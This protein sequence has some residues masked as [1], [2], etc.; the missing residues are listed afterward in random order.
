MLIRIPKPWEKI[1]A[2]ETPE[3]YFENRRSFLKLGGAAASALLLGTRSAV[4]REAPSSASPGQ[5]APPAPRD[6][7]FTLDPPVTPERFSSRHNVFDEFSLERDPVWKLADSL[8]T[9]PWTI[10]IGGL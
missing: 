1:A 8:R 10:H 4:S 7:R 5:P 6:P 9:R 2:R 3:R